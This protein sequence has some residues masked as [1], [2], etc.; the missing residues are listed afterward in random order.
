MGFATSDDAAVY[1]LTPGL[2][3]V[4]TVD[5]FPP[6]VDDPFAFGPI[7]A[8]NALSRHLGHGRA[9]RCSRSTW[10]RF[11]KELPLTMLLE[12]P[13]GRRSRKADEAGIPI[14][15]GHS[16]QDPEPKYGMAV[17]GVVHPQ[18]G[19][20]QRGRASRATCSSSPSRWARASPPPRSSAG[21]PRKELDRSA[22]SR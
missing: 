2:A 6:V 13:R 8:A 16:V 4:E 1:R 20:H 10:W 5:F 9:G 15:G 18:E 7:A 17:T 19:A 22:W 21:S 3:V 11:P 12:D 14:L